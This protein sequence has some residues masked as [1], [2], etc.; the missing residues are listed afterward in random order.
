MLENF[1]N[2]HDDRTGA[3]VRTFGDEIEVD[4]ASPSQI[5]GAL[6]GLAGISIALSQQV[7]L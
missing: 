2:S 1:K 5:R 7:I 4:G 3:L 6:L